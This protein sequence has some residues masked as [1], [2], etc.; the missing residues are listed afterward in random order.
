[1][2][3]DYNSGEKVHQFIFLFGNLTCEFLVTKRKTLFVN[4]V[5]PFVLHLISSLPREIKQRARESQEK[6]DTPITVKRERE[7][8]KGR[9][10][11]RERGREKRRYQITN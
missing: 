7:M 5:P 1:M 10:G 2:T 3:T 4:I 11:E 8:E 9:K 6:L